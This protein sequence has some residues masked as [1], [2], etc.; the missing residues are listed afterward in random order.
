MFFFFFFTCILSLSIWWI[1]FLKFFHNG[2]QF[3]EHGNASLQVGLLNEHAMKEANF[4][5]EALTTMNLACPG[6]F[7]T[8]GLELHLMLS[9]DIIAALFQA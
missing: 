8:L 4:N 7:R 2:D 1:E 6:N 5:E 3:E 9:S